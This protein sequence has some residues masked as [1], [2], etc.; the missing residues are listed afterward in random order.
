MKRWLKNPWAPGLAALRP[1]PWLRTPLFWLLACN[2][3]LGLLCYRDFGLSWDEPL[4]YQYAE[5]V[6][7]AYSIRERL[8]G[9]FDLERAYGPS[10]GDH[11]MYGP[12]YLLLARPLVLTLDWA[13]PGGLAEAWHLTNFLTFQA[14]VAF[15][16]LLAR[17]WM[18][19]IAAFGA[20]L[21][22]AVQPVLWGH[23]WINPKDT[24]FAAFFLAAVWFGL[25]MVDRLS[26]AAPTTVATSAVFRPWKRLR[27][28]IRVLALLGLVLTLTLFLF[29]SGLQSLF[30]SLVQSAYQAAPQSLTGRLFA[31]LAANA[32]QVPVEAYIQKGVIWLVRLRLLVT[33]VSGLL[34]IAAALLTFWPDV[35]QRSAAWLAGKLAP[36]PTWPAWWLPSQSLGALLVAV[37]PA[38]LAL[39]LLSAIRVIGPLAGLLV[40][41]YFFLRAEPRPLAGLALYAGLAF[42]VMVVAWPYLW[43]SPL[44]RLWEA[45]RHMSNNPQIVSVVFNGTEYPSDRLPRSYLP[46]MLALTLTLPTWPLSFGGLAA[47]W[48]RLARRE[49][50]WRSLGVLLLWFWLMVAYVLIRRPP[51]YD[52]YRHFLFILPPVFIL[53]GLALEWLLARIRRIE[54]KALLLLAFVLPGLFGLAR[55]HPYPYTYYNA[56]AGGV[57]GA[58]RRF[59]TDYWLTCYREIMQQVN[60]DLAPGAT[61]FVHRQPA[62]AQAYASQGLTVLRFDPDDDQTF[63]GSML[64]LSS[65]T[66]VD[67]KVHPEAPI[68]Y[69]VGRDGAV[70]CVVKRIP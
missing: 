21:L 58:A 68:L 51:M 39:G 24:P 63:P 66:N 19:Q 16:Y 35:V 30:S 55:L 32:Q 52:G 65:R 3:L 22:Y 36:R 10:A 62:I 45:L 9:D 50:E 46:L 49:I 23:A 27:R 48:Q 2:L 41:L 28:T 12:A 64:L 7:Y 1:P 14:G 29:W 25:G 40:A 33:A 4:F 57:G 56:L 60:A 54:L 11:K 8:D 61:L 69:Q 37:L 5:A 42:L 20:A 31:L 34:L 67:Q 26:A 70:F 18:G 44:A 17:R 43:D 59:E 15:L 6:P 53:A 13:L 47:A 38:A